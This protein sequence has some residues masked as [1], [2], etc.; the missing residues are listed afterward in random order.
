M[1]TEQRAGRAHLYEYGTCLGPLSLPLS[2]PL[3]LHE[4]FLVYPSFSSL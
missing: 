1:S 3:L 2:A 4:V